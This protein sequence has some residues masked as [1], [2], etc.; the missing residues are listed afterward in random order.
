MS[1][2]FTFSILFVSIV[3]DNLLMN[4]INVDNVMYIRMGKFT[5]LTLSLGQKKKRRN[6]TFSFKS[7][8]SRKSSLKI[9]QTCSKPIFLKMTG[10][11]FIPHC[12]HIFACKISSSQ[13]GIKFKHT[14][15]K[16]DFFKN[17]G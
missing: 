13:Y 5:N 2:T 10:E 3:F 6:K 11:R 7:S 14:L 8:F 17:N 9:Y 4:I 15:N 16:L 1:L 12:L